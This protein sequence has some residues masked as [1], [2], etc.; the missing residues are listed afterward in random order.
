M[1]YMLPIHKMYLCIQYANR[2]KYVYSIYMYIY[3]HDVY[4]SSLE[5]FQLIDALPSPWTLLAVLVSYLVVS[6]SSPL[7]DILRR[8]LASI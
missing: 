4:I 5:A 3:I 2:I 6:N 1:I 7:E 8:V